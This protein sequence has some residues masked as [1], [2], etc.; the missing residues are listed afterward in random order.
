M[1]SVVENSAADDRRWYV[2]I[3]VGIGT[4]LSSLNTSI[5]NI[6]LPFIERSLHLSLSQSEWIVLIYLLVLTLFLLPIGRV[7]DLWG[8]RSIF[9]SG[10]VLFACAAAVCGL[11]KSYLPLIL[12]RGFLGLAGAMILSVGP[13]LITTAFSASERGKVLGIQAIMTYI[14]LSLGPVLGG[15][16]TQLWGWPFTFFIAIPFSFIG[17]LIGIWAVPRVS[18]KRHKP[19]DVPGVFCF[20]ILMAAMTLMLNADVIARYRQIIIALLFIMTI[21]FGLAFLRNERRQAA[22][23]LDI[24]L[25]R[26][27][28][29]GFGMFGAAFNYLCF[30]LTLFL[31]PFYLDRVLHFSAAETGALMTITPIM[32]T[33][34]SPIAGALSDRIGSRML[35]VSGMIASALSLLLFAV[36]G[37]VLGGAARWLFMI[38]GLILAGIGTGIFAAPNNSAVL[39]AAPREQ[40]GMASGALATFRYIG[41]MAGITVGGSLL[42]LLLKY[43][44]AGLTATQAFL[45]S[46]SLVMLIGTFFGVIGTACTLSMTK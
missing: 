9:L 27:R 16:L 41:M 46:F 13:A 10:F 5:T 45:H 1:I 25:F 29:F 28:S 20:M 4:F 42:D 30:F 35:T 15:W 32:M 44:G 40:Q 38:P 8:Y 11:S 34:C 7:A 21:S 37:H 18:V 33:V 12:G 3:T 22:P 24:G 6:V 19:I 14:G 39:G 17:L 36:M 31:L 43:S 2:L 23:M 26:I